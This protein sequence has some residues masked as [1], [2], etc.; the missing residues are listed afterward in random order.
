[1]NMPWSK[2]EGFAKALSICVTVLLVSSGLCG[3]QW[4][5]AM[6]NN[7]LGSALSGVIVFFG[8]IELIA[9]AL[10]AAGTVVI[11][12]LWAAQTLY[13]HF[14]GRDSSGAKDEHIQTLFPNDDDQS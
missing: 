7:G 11:L 9:I 2:F 5:F 13:F 1:M 10:S 8:V 6:G 3:V 12:I 14:S 4:F